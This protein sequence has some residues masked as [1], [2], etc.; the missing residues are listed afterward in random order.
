MM[1]VG[2][3]IMTWC[4]VLCFS[5]RANDTIPLHA[6]PPI[7]TIIIDPGHGGRDGG[8]QGKYN[9]E[10]NLALGISLKVRD[11]LKKGVPGLNVLMTRTTDE[12]PGKLTDK[13]AA[14]RW[15]ANFANQNAGDL[16]IS[17]HL[18]ASPANQRYG[19]KQVGSK[20][21]TYYTYTGKGKNRKKIKKT[22]TVPVYEKYKLPATVYGTQTYI[23]ARDWYKGKVSAVNQQVLDEHAHMG[24]ESDSLSEEMLDLDPI[25]AKIRAAQYT[26][27]YFTK[28]MSLAEMVE[29]EFATIGRKSWGVL[30]RDWAGIW[31]LQATQMPCILIETG[32]IDH[33]EEEEYLTSSEGQTELAKAIVK[34]IQRYIQVLSTSDN[35]VSNSGN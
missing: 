32:F 25:E 21:Q 13:N 22:R 15:R 14:L 19:K 28:S 11:E 33:P 17:I 3:I 27:L 4:S 12:L 34:G 31:V 9:N 6:N 23:L 5:A 20:Q 7:R 26:K 30:Q 29:E 24:G 10:A 2:M 18:N 8:A 16:F 1:K 35:A